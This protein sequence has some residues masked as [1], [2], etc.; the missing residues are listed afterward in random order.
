MLRVRNENPGMKKAVD[1]LAPYRR[2]VELQKQMIEL[3]E[4]HEQSKRRRDALRELMARE[5]IDRQPVRRGLRHR[6]QRSAAKLLKRVPGFAAGK[7]N[8]GALNPKQPSSC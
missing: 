3:A 4:Q 6:L 7:P 2:L 5:V 8:F 1:D